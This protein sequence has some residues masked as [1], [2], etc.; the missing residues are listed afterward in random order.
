MLSGVTTTLKDVQDEFLKLVYKETILGGHSLEN[1]L[2]ALKISH[3]LVIDTAVPY[4]HPVVHHTKQHSRS[5]EIQDSSCGHDRPEFGA[6]PRLVRR[7]LLTILTE[8]GKTS[9]FIDDVSIVKQYASGTC[10]AFPV[11]SDE[12]AL[13]KVT[14][15]VKNEKTHFVWTQFSELNSNFKK[16]SSDTEKLNTRIAGMISLLTCN[17][18]SV[19]RKAVKC[20]VN[21]EL[22]DV[23]TRLNTGV[24]NLYSNLPTNAM[25]IICTGHGDT[26]IVQRHEAKPETRAHLEEYLHSRESIQSWGFFAL[27]CLV[28]K[29]AR[30]SYTSCKAFHH[31]KKGS[32]K[33]NTMGSQ[34]NNQ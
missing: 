25:L 3:N 7:K 16:Q 28:K 2:L 8:S 33:L 30:G 23:L 14:K 10:N 32:I 12:E 15:E 11:C 17:Q 21:S 31:H 9:S 1:G 5:L 27:E 6:P 19:D 13:S 4:K 18:K 26:A 29:L 24:Q 20:K 34:P 22:K